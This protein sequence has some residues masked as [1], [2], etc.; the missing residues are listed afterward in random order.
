[1]DNVLTLLKDRAY[2]SGM[3]GMPK[4]YDVNDTLVKVDYD[5]ATDE[6]FGI[7]A[8]GHPYPPLKAVGEGSVISEEDFNK[9]KA[10]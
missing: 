9:A 6:V 4:F 1:M 3:D 5:K 10:K 2:S 8:G 7:T